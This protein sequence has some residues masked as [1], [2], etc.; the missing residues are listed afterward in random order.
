MPRS[1]RLCLSSRPRSPCRPGA[2]S[3]RV[4]S[5]STLSAVRAPGLAAPGGGAGPCSQVPAR[6]P[7]WRRGRCARKGSGR[8]PEG[9]GTER[10][11]ERGL[12]VLLG[13][14]LLLLRLVGGPGGGVPDLE[15]RVG[16]D[17]DAVAVE[18]GVLPQPGRHGDAALLVGRLVGGAGEEHP[19]VVAVALRRQRGRLQLLGLRGER[20]TGEQVEATLLPPCDHHA[21]GQLVTE[22]GRQEQPALVVEARGVGAEEHGR[23]TPL[24]PMSSTLLHFPPSS[25]RS[26][27]L[28]RSFWREK[29]RSAPV[30]LRWGYKPDIPDLVR[31]CRWS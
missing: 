12:L 4:L 1:S 27:Y 20:P 21:S 13:E 8:R 25:T 17:D 26:R 19:A 5:I 9:R 2:C 16:A 3:L 23:P 31:R 14:R 29:R 18:A 30:V 22:L 6:S 7:A 15:P 24:A 10:L 11:E 28:R